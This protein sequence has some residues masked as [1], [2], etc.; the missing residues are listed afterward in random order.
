MVY[1]SFFVVEEIL[2]VFFSPVQLQKVTLRKLLNLSMWR[3]SLSIVNT[4]QRLR[5]GRWPCWWEDFYLIG[6]SFILIL[7]HKITKYSACLMIYKTLAPFTGGSS[8]P[9]SPRH[10]DK[11]FSVQ[12]HWLIKS[13]RQH[14]RITMGLEWGK[15]FPLFREQTTE[16]KCDS[17]KL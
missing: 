16:K 11:F 8:F 6:K 2:V 10:Q 1:I 13:Y 15:V 4:F 14:W 12:I 5:H 17:F 7:R 9:M 3:N